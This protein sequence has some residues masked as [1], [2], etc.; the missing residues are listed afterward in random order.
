MGHALNFP[1]PEKGGRGKTVRKAD[2]FSKQRLSE[3]RTVL[4]YSR[5]LALKVRD[6]SVKLAQALATV[7]DARSAAHR[8]GREIGGGSGHGADVG[9]AAASP[10]GH[11]WGM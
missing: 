9:H 3:A 8:L 4:A 7:E 6:G 5:E 2:S 1:E 10:R 11:L